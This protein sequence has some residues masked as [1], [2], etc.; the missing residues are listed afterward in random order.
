MNSGGADASAED[1]KR[2]RL[3]AWRRKQQQQVAPVKVS[4]SLSVSV[5][6]KQK[7]KVKNKKKTVTPRPAPNAFFGDVDSDE[8]ND[9]DATSNNRRKRPLDLFL[10]ESAT[11][12]SDTAA[13]EQPSTK[14]SKKSKGSSR[15]D[16]PAAPAESASSP[17]GKDA[18]DQFMDKLEA[19]ALTS[20]HVEASSELNIHVGGSMMRQRP[21]PHPVSGGVIT[22]EELQ[23]KTDR[24]AKAPTSENVTSNDKVAEDQ[25]L[26]Q[27]SDWLSDAAADTDDEKEEEQQARRA[28]IE[29]LK[30]TPGPLVEDEE[31][32]ASRPAQLASEVKSEKHRREE[33]LKELEVQA[34]E[35]RQSAMAEQSD[36]GVLSYNDTEEG[37]ME[38]A[39]RNLQA[40]KAAPDALLVLA[41]LNKKKELK[42]VDHSKVD[43]LPIQKNLYRVPKKLASLQH[44]EVINRRAKLKVRVRGH[45]APA[46]VESFEQCGLSEKILQILAQQDIHTPYP[47]QAQC[48]PCIMAGRDVIGIAKTGSGKTLAYVLPML[49]HILVQPPLEQNESGPIGLVLAPARELAYQ[50]HVV[51][52]SFGKQ[53]GIK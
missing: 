34:E 48:I 40:A 17:A 15:W 21:K 51:C 42:A 52:R 13:Q 41:E 14:R 23:N 50:I 9:N 28:L 16:K 24:K 33:R 30:S 7:K 29:A 44:D 53:L 43:Y 38:E 12:A 5:N 35:A 22:A 36:F 4:L 18:L 37:I 31:D 11:P 49:R 46:P 10:D 3:E 8:Y 6:Q 27:P 2:K 45:G 1:R 26:Y 25:P 20:A 47:I 19:G 32:D 39:E